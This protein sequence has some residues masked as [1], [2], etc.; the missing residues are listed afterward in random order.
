MKMMMAKKKI[1]DMAIYEYGFILGN[2][3]V[4]IK[5]DRKGAILASAEEM[6]RHIKDLS[7]YIKKNPQILYALEPLEVEPEAPQI[8]RKMAYASKMANVG[9]MASVAG[10]IADFGLEALLRM[11]SNIAIVEDGG[12]ISASTMEDIPISI[13]TS[14]RK[15]SGKIGLLITNDDSPIGIATSTGKTDRVVSFGEADSVTVVAENAATADAAATSICN[16]IVGLDAVRSILKG[17]ERAKNI[18]GV[19]GAIIIRNGQ[20]G[21]VGKLPKIIR[22]RD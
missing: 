13:I 20:V 3:K 6:K 17:L 15:L 14:E 22:I 2:S 12:E 16:A 7:D 21:L 1:G 8:I 9:P 11:G 19:R 10:A 5:C 18:R 4:H